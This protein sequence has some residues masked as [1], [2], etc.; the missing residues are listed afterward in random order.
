[1]KKIQFLLILL[2]YHTSNAQN[3]IFSDKPFAENDKTGVARDFSLSDRIYARAIFSDKIV[4]SV[5]LLK[6]GQNY[7][8]PID[9][10]VVRGKSG[11]NLRKVTLWISA[12][13][14]LKNQLDF[15]VLSAPENVRSVYIGASGDFSV[16]SDMDHLFNGFKN[17]S[18]G[19]ATVQVA[20]FLK[21]EETMAKGQLKLKLTESDNAA[22]N[23]RVY[24]VDKIRPAMKSAFASTQGLP[25]IFK[26]KTSPFSDPELSLEKIG[27]LFKA[28]FNVD[29]VHAV[30]IDDNTTADYEIRYNELGQPLYK[31]TARP[32]VIAY[33]LQGKCKYKQVM[34]QRNHLGSG[35]YGNLQFADLVG[36]PVE[37]NCNSFKQ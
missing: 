31:Y 33:R 36:E 9:M 35:K 26:K 24:F 1:M 2:L 34:L 17:L 32:I 21:D 23:L 6:V 8:L 3:I 16:E 5:Y 25:P 18:P 28:E 10:N 30:A 22:E 4:N 15:D 13:D 19:T 20:F 37:I 7:A 29:E 14:V 27:K 11:M 12:Q